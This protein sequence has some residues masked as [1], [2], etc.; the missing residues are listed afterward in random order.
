MANNPR[1]GSL[2]VTLAAWLCFT[3]VLLGPP[4]ARAAQPAVVVAEAVQLYRD[5][6]AVRARETLIRWLERP[7]AREPAQRLPALEALLD[8][9][10]HSY[11]ESCVQAYAAPYAELARAAPAANDVLGAEQVRKAAYYFDYGR[12]ALGQ[13]EVT[14]TILDG[15]PWK[16]ENAYNGEL[17]LRRQLLAT[18][19]LLAQ[20]RRDEALTAADKVLSLVASLKNPQDSRSTVA[21]VLADVIRTLMDLGQIERAYGLYRASGGFI[22]RALPEHS[23]D[24]AVFR[25][26]E[27]QLL[28]AVGDLTGANRALASATGTLREIELDDDTR[29]WLLGRAL[30]LRAMVCAAQGE[31]DCA[32]EAL[33]TH[34]LAELYATSGR[35]PASTDEFAYLGA[36]SLVAVLEGGEDPVAGRAMASAPSG[37]DAG[38]AAWI[39]VARS[40]G[41]AV[42]RAPG[43][44]RKAALMALGRR[45][46]AAVGKDPGA[47]GAWYRPEAAD[48]VVLGLALAEAGGADPET[49]FALFQLAARDGPSFDAD[50]LTVLGQARSEPQRRAIHQALRLRA[51][52]DRLE[53]EQ[54]QAVVAKGIDAAPASAV[55]QHDPAQRLVL[56]D[57]SRRI[58]EAERGMAKDGIPLSGANLAPLRLFQARLAPDEAALITAPVAG[59]LAYMCVR[60]DGVRQSVGAVDMLRLRVDSRLLEAALTATH[61]PS[62]DLDAQ[63]PAEAAVRLYDALIRPFEACLKPGDRIVW[64]PSVTTAAVPLAALLPRVPP[65]VANGYD[66]A[67]ADWLVRRHAISYAG[68]ASVILAARSGGAGQG[69]AFDF[70]G[71]GDPL[72]SGTT[73]EGQARGKAVLRGVRGG[74]LAE[75][76]PLPETKDELA[77]SARGFRTTRLLL[78]EEATERRLRGELV[79]A[80]RYLSFATHGLIRDDLQ[81]LAEPALVLTPV[82]SQDAADD[83][84]F[85]ASE[86]ADLNLRARFVALSACNTANFDLSQMSQDLPALASAFAVAGTPSTLATLWPVNS[87]AGKRVVAATF[88]GLQATPG[89]GPAQALAAAQRAFLAD[90]PS[91]AYLHPRFWAPF[92]VLGDGG[93]VPAAPTA[94][95]SP[96]LTSVEVLTR[97][98]GEA[99]DVR[100]ERAGVSARL[101]ARAGESGRY[102]A[103]FRLASV[104]GEV[105]RH[106]S[107]GVGAS[108]FTVEIGDRLVASGYQ[109]GPEGHFAPTLEA[110]DP[111]SGEVAR[112][113][114]GDG[115]SPTDAFVFAGASLGPEQ[116]VILTAELRGDAGGPR[117]RLLKVDAGLEPR[118]LAD[119]AAPSGAYVDDAT[120]T[121]VGSD[122]F[123]TYTDRMARRAA[124]PETLD[125]WET[126]YCL[127]ERVTWIER[128]DG[129]TG[130]LKASR[131]IRGLAVVAAVA[132]RGG[133]VLLGGSATAACGEDAQAAVLALDAKLATRSLYRD[134]TI[135]A[136]EVRALGLLPKEGVIV[137]ASKQA[138]LDI[139]PPAAP[140]LA[141]DPYRLGILPFSLAGMVFALSRDGRVSPPRMLDSGSTVFVTS[142]DAS[143]P[144]DVLLGGSLGGEAA[145]FHL[146][147]E[148]P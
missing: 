114:R 110:F 93:A 44:A 24:A 109:R 91:R 37:L 130:A 75:L 17:Y 9:C 146:R 8:I 101:I 135:G 15:D 83:G 144:G 115:L 104:A 148:R 123:V 13:P 143:Q 134:G 53:R 70:L 34:P 33:R 140:A 73:Q 127:G 147:A 67:A 124:S 95:D 63:F 21:W 39:D 102:G 35:T 82:S 14:A 62:E 30:S 86:I 132:A 29:V 1:F 5:G 80:Y 23:V 6:R 40:A 99:V 69:G 136:S 72:L 19:V 56:R 113:W 51:R 116:A 98:G 112:R 65:K 45:L 106:E 138:V 107:A 103:G 96:G 108:R 12:F 85:T 81:G 59:G 61:A 27:A 76:A 43:P 4:L 22:G 41:A 10:I 117:L 100:R 128:R 119:F 90:P 20:G 133:E 28:Q 89:V 121:V 129:R 97:G 57:F 3:S 92:V 25:L 26:A 77:A 18:D 126:R 142:L 52:R 64:L 58:A 88:A 105:W 74:E 137:A 84:L 50:A 60:R 48:R 47:A 7:E 111:V 16:H 32:R 68:S 118:M 42:V 139:R 125:D 55:L 122:L 79:G 145:I 71:V 131:E 2:L 120:V 54:V 36:R 49:A 78:Q 141:A 31:L 38:E 87:E 94:A 46:T 11:A 66:L